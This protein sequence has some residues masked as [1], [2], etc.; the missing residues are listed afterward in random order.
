LKTLFEGRLENEAVCLSL[1]NGQFSREK[2]GAREEY[3]PFYITNGQNKSE[4]HGFV[5]RSFPS[6]LFNGHDDAERHG[7]VITKAK[8]E[9]PATTTSALILH[10]L[11]EQILYIPLIVFSFL[12]IPSRFMRKFICRLRLNEVSRQ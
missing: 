8:K 3:F 10:Q 2:Q 6:L 9:T 11:F 5:S 4:C 7:F 12:Q 1:Y